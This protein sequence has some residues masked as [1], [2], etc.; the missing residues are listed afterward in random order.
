MQLSCRYSLRGVYPYDFYLVLLSISSQSP[1]SYLF[2]LQDKWVIAFKLFAMKTKTIKAAMP[3]T[4]YFSDQ[5][6]FL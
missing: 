2:L 3:T 4:S 5:F 6:Y 1:G